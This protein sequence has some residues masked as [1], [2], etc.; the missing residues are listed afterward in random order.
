MEQSLDFEELFLTLNEHKI[1][2][3]VVGAH[4]VM[5]YTEPRYTKDL[6][7]WIIPSL[8]DVQKIH[9]ALKD[10][11]APIDKLAPTEF[12]NEDLIF[13]IGVPPVRIDILMNIPGVDFRT[14]W[15]N[16][17]RTKYGRARIY[18]LGIQELMKAKKQ[19]GRHQDL[20]DL[21]NLKR[22]LKKK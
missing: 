10:F 11:G 7:I 13:Q 2:Y 14:A 19:I 12:K 6:D 17:T 4:A 1:Q 22:S 3:I 8:N 5:Y 16:K 9:Q 15:K 21:E 18:V 20:A